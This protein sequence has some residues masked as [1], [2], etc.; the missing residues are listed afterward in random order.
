MFHNNYIKGRRNTMIIVP[1][2]VKQYV[3]SIIREYEYFYEND[4]ECS[5]AT[6]IVDG[7]K[8]TGLELTKY[9]LNRAKEFRKALD[10]REGGWFEG[11]EKEIRRSIYYTAIS[12]L[13]DMP[14]KSIES[15][16][17]QVSCEEKLMKAL[18][19]ASKRR[20]YI[21]KD[22]KDL[23]DFIANSQ[24]E[25][26]GQEDEHIKIRH[27][28]QIKKESDF[29]A[30]IAKDNPNRAEKLDF[31][32]EPY[33]AIRIAW[34]EITIPQ[35]CREKNI[36]HEFDALFTDPE[37]RNDFHTCYE[38]FKFWY[39]LA[40]IGEYF[41]CIPT[42]RSIEEKMKQKELQEKTL[43]DAKATTE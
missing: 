41:V 9:Q 2:C 23:L 15:V 7:K 19:T 42:Q 39:G 20:R 6:L 29:E 33:V 43:I 40:E 10:T 32:C 34:R 3:D 25:S 22:A 38:I 12:F 17:H 5:C 18:T 4:K 28:K 27:F 37:Q 14:Y 8:Y 1:D 13:D 31:D 35:Q 21:R 24:H 16:M 11:T 30:L 36:Y 26:W